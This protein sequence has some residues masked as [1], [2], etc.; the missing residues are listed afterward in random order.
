[1]NR[2]KQKVWL[3]DLKIMGINRINQ[4]DAVPCPFVCRGSTVYNIII[5]NFALVLINLLL[6]TPTGRYSVSMGH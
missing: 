4:Q 6:S 3:L 5:V 1:M 2:V